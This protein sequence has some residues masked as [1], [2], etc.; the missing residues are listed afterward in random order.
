[1]KICFLGTGASPSSPLPFCCCE[2]CR[3]SRMAG[4]ENL[5]KR[6]SLLI[7]DDLLIDI[8]PDIF[9]ASG[10]YGI[11]LENI[12]ICLQTHPHGDHFDPEMII[13]R[14]PD[15][16]T[17]IKNEMTIIASKETLMV[18]DS[19]INSKCDYGSIFDKS[20]QR[21]YGIRVMPIAAYE[22]LDCGGYFITAYPANHGAPDQ[23]FMI[24]SVMR[25][26][27]SILY[28][29]D[30]SVIFEE[31]WLK[32]REYNECFDVIV[33]DHTYGAGIEP[34][35]H[36]SLKA[37]VDHV[38]R[39]REEGLLKPNGLVYATHISHEGNYLYFEFETIAEEFGYHIAYD[40]LQIELE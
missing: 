33:L 36:L 5:R 18:M 31:V 4:G 13:S 14:H 37:F 39:F 23:G 34:S 32:M 28:A 22:R 2:F 35:D 29:T 21:N 11:P 30:T 15:Y 26:G 20:A 19:I 7:N 25:G 24:Y 1:M 3:T 27:R 8:G 38:K 17:V 10:Q 9:S 12:R 40:G 16:A 6:S